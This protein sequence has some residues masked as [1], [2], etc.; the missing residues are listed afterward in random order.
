M[1]DGS[2]DILSKLKYI[3]AR[4]VGGA[5]PSGA[6]AVARAEPVRRSSRLD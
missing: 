5:T 2:I 4:E 1:K 6:A 3:A